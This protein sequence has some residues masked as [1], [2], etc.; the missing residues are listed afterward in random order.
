VS[1]G[2]SAHGRGLPLWRQ[3]A[4]Q[5]A[6]E[7][8]SGARTPGSK[9]PSVVELQE[10]RGIS[11]STTMRAYRELANQGLLVAVSGSGSYVADPIP[12]VA[13]PVPEVLSEHEARLTKLERLVEELRNR[14]TA[15]DPNE[16]G[17]TS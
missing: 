5:L 14:V 7:I 17:E 1:S 11:Q 10:T 13:R 2:Q 6:T 3:L 4:D 16:V 15:S 12:P 8:R 9:L